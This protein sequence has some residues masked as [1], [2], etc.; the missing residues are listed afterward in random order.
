MAGCKPD[1]PA[2]RSHLAEPG[3][4]RLAGIWTV[5]L[6]VASNV[7]LPAHGFRDAGTLALVLNRERVTTSL[8]G[9]PPVAFGT[10]DIPFDSMGV[11]SG[12]PLGTPDVWA[13]VAGDSVTLTLSPR[14]K[15]PITLTGRWAG[16]SLTGRWTT[17]QRAGP[18]GLGDF[19]LRRR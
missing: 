16:D 4:S 2:W 17:E 11:S 7:G 14:A 1:M 3:I 12:D 10:Y 9:T 15:W 13:R 18:G 6:S 8:F 5:E 19:V